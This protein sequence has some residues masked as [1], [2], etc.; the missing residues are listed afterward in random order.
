MY[1]LS[2][3]VLPSIIILIIIRKY[4]ET[5]WGKC[6]NKVRLDGKIAIVTGANSGLGLEIAKELA[7]RNAQVILACRNLEK[8]N[9]ACEYIRG[10]SK[11]SKVMLIPM[12]LDL[13]SLYSIKNFA[14]KIK[15]HY[16]EI[17]ILINNAGVAFPNTK[18]VETKD[19]FEVHFGVNHLGTFY[20]TNLLLEPLSASSGNNARVVVVAS[21]LHEKGVVNVNDLNSLRVTKKTN[22]YANSKLMNIYF[23]QELSRRIKSKKINVYA[24]CP[25]WVYTALFRHSIKWYH[26]FLIAPV[27]FFFMRSPK[28][29]VQTPVYCATEPEL[30]TE[31]GLLYRDCK[32]YNSKV[33]F[34]D[35]IATKLWE[36]SESMINKIIKK[37]L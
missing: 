24:C 27:A 13:A 29:G 8:A 3:Y 6:K 20:L 2:Y 30:E 23:A 32:R 10:T 33:I 36:E 19:G 35:N 11:N 4:R 15:E 16:Q 1:S 25:G 18:R 34:Y 14:D 22:L 9:T 26:Y 12:E 37:E 5:K 21:S 28:Q 7:A 31:T 17:N